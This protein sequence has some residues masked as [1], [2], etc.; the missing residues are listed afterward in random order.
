MADQTQRP[1]RKQL[2]VDRRVQ[3]ELMFRTATYWLYCLL[4]LTMLTICWQIYKAPQPEPFDVHLDAVKANFGP[5]ALGSLLI[6]PIVL[7]DVLR[8]S[9]R[10][11]GPMVRVRRLLRQLADGQDVPELTFR[12]G[13]FWTEFAGEFN[14]VAQRF[15]ELEAK[16]ARLESEQETVR[17]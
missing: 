8:I 7:V 13:D 15:R 1:L 11:T 6:L 4:T 12:D 9:N 10:F 14:A 2:F 5:V 17:A 3:G 16:L